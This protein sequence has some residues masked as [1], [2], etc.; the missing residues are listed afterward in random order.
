MRKVPVTASD[1][2]IEYVPPQSLRPYPGNA[3]THSRRQISVIEASIR[4]FD[5]MQPALISKDNEIIAGHGRVEAA[6]SLGLEKIPTIRIEHLSET[7]RRAYVIADNKIAQMAGWDKEILAIELQNLIEV[8]F[9]LEIVGFDPPEVDFLFEG[10]SESKCDSSAEDISPQPTYDGPS[11][12]QP[13]DIWLLGPKGRPRH[14]LICGDARDSRVFQSLLGSELATLL[15]TDPPYNVRIGGV[16]GK[17]RIQ[18]REFA[19]AS[20]EMSEGQFIEF[21]RQFL[22]ASLQTMGS[23]GLAYVLMVWGH[24]FELLSAAR[25]LKLDL[26]NLCV[27]NKSNGGMGSLYRSKH[28]LVCIFGQ[29]KQPHRNN[30]ELGKHGR[31]RA[32]VWDYHGESAF[33]LG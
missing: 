13:G 17:G 1:Y 20:G 2:R 4:R 15:L 24:L 14:R 25:L 22:K 6:K 28:E 33:H 7:D 30:V 26:V 31:N 11:V 27:W 9:D 32:N 12:T 8:G 10:L 19:M 23:G 16:S 3:R 29:G 21:L 5:F 18:H